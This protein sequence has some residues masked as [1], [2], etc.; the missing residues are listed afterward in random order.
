MKR[1]RVAALL[2][3]G[4]M[5]F[6]S[7]PVWGAD[8]ASV[9]MQVE[10]EEYSPEE[11]EE[12][13]VTE[14]KSNREDDTAPIDGSTDPATKPNEEEISETEIVDPETIEST[15]Q[16]NSEQ[17]NKNQDSNEGEADQEKEDN[18]LEEKLPEDSEQA[19]V[20]TENKGETTHHSTQLENSIANDAD[21]LEKNENSDVVEI[22][23]ERIRKALKWSDKNG[24]GIFTR[25]ELSEIGSTISY[26]YMEGDSTEP[27]DLEG[28]QYIGDCEGGLSIDLGGK[29]T[30]KNPEL[31][32]QI[33]D[34]KKFYFLDIVNAG[35]SDASFVEKAAEI[36]KLRLTGN[37]ITNCD[38]LKNKSIQQIDL[39]NNQISDISGVTGVKTDNL[40]LNNNLI[41]DILPLT[42]IQPYTEGYELS[43]E[44]SN[45]QIETLPDNW[46]NL[47]KI[48]WLLLSGNQLTSVKVLKPLLMEKEFVTIEIAD[49]SGLTEGKIFE[50]LFDDRE[51]SVLVGNQVDLPEFKF[52]EVKFEVE[53]SDIAELTENNTVI[54]ISGGKTNIIAT[55]SGVS[56][57]IPLTV[58]GAIRPTTVEKD[59]KPEVQSLYAGA[60]A[61]LDAEGALW[62]I[63]GEISEKIADDAV[64]YVPAIS[65]DEYQ[66][67]Q[68]VDYYVL[69]DNHELIYYT[70]NSLSDPFEKT[71]LYTDVEDFTVSSD[72][73]VLAVLTTDHKLRDC[74]SNQI[75]AENVEKYVSDVNESGS[76]IVYLA[77]TLDKKILDCGTIVAENAENVMLNLYES[78]LYKIGDTL[79]EYYYTSSDPGHTPKRPILVYDKVKEW[80]SADQFIA[81]DGQRY[82]WINRGTITLTPLN[83]ETDPYPEKK[84]IRWTGYMLDLNNVLWGNSFET[85]EKVIIAENV[86]DLEEVTYNVSYD[87]GM[88]SA[89]TDIIY[90]TSDNQLVG[91]YSGIVI[92]NVKSISQKFYLKADGTL[93]EMAEG[94][95]ETNNMILPDV[96][97]YQEDVSSEN[98]DR[99]GCFMVR[100]DGSVW[101]YDSQEGPNA[102]PCRVLTGILVSGDLD[103]DGQV[104]VA[105]MLSILHGISGSDPL[106]E[107]QKLAGDIDGDGQVSVKDL[108]RVLHFIS[109]ASSEL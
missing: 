59:D 32:S 10:M 35:L 103:G 96:V 8:N 51:R 58:E 79:Y 4:T 68:N 54:G 63:Q 66:Q 93:Y 83:E 44:C 82:S 75:V 105:D 88:G 84:S 23:D 106:D 40:K 38:F 77:Y 100:K 81:L 43:I 99:I 37:Q 27:L 62:N 46:P 61:A 45:N 24:D 1:E 76:G 85:G 70:R 6:T 12:A 90:L 91:I 87:H 47:M 2:L 11:T 48:N 65:Y 22:P 19:E 71:I 80:L 107:T 5:V 21:T 49:N 20:E 9:D 25:E 86:Q 29:V 109:G 14:E 34:G 102:I 33:V 50:D 64:S 56:I 42:T 60:C 74:I 73:S 26:F 52:G 13:V 7:V 55:S 39:S 16:K 15:E 53:S 72:N 89:S 3:A 67:V 97:S 98:A 57:T 104:Q 94:L 108:L 78:S 30:I 28:L 92:D 41:K 69:N 101:K 18:F 31:L 95:S 36:G 17:E